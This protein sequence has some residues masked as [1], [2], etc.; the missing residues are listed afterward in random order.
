[1]WFLS[2]LLLLLS[3]LEHL[4]EELEL[5]VREREE[6]E[7]GGEEGEVEIAWHFG[8]GGSTASQRKVED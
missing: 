5:C 3:S 8:C 2:S 4:L 1:L 6:E 7:Q